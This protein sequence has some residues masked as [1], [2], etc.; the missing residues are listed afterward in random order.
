MAARR[1]EPVE[2]ALLR[3]HAGPVHA[4]GLTPKGDEVVTGGADR[5]VRLWNVDLRD[6]AV[7]IC[8]QAVPRMTG[9]EWDRYFAG[10]DFAPPCRD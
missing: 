2:V 8:E 4:V 7:R 9:T 3:G 5:A 10:L 1:G 6:P